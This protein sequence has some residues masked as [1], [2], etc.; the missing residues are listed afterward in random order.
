MFINLQTWKQWKFNLSYQKEKWPLKKKV[1]QIIQNIKR[2][3]E[4]EKIF[5]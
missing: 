3:N 5:H 4:N 1:R 2:K